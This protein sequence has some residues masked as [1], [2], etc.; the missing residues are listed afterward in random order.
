MTYH[1]E[2]V[3]VDLFEVFY[4]NN[5][6]KVSLG[7]CGNQE[8]IDECIKTHTY[9]HAKELFTSIVRTDNLDAQCLYPITDLPESFTEDEYKMKYVELMLKTGMMSPL[10]YLTKTRHFLN[11]L[12]KYEFLKFDGKFIV[13]D[14]LRSLADEIVELGKMLGD[15]IDTMST[16]E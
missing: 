14:G 16:G 2:E 11:I 9:T 8:E 6:E 12:L 10:G 3:A 5:D 7:F 15:T 4:R 13:S 1:V